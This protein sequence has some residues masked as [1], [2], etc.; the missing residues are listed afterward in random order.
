MSVHIGRVFTW[1]RY[2]GNIGK[3]YRQ[4]LWKVKVPMVLD[5]G[6]YLKGGVGL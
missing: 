5:K 6:E 2:G 1:S 4:G 3:P